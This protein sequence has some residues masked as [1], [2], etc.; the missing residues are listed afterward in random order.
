[1]FKIGEKIVCIDN[2]ELGNNNSLYYL[3]YSDV[4]TVTKSGLTCVAIN[5]ID[6]LY[7]ASRFISLKEQRNK[8][9]KQLQNENK[10]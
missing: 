6:F 8:K 5:N 9:L 2:L 3:N 7:L 4:Y 1:M 10:M